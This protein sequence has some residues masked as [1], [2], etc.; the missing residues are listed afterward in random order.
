ML[1]R[2]FHLGPSLSDLSLCWGAPPCGPGLEP[3]RQPR[4]FREHKEPWEFTVNLGP[5]ENQF[6]VS[7]TNRLSVLITN[8][9]FLL[10]SACK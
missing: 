3:T 6:Q 4:A 1:Q 10:I 2:R 5:A 9:L 8:K 7:E